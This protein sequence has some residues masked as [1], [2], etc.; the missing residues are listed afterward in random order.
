MSEA[1]PLALDAG[2]RRRGPTLAGGSPRRALRLS[3]AGWRTLAQLQGG[4]AR[5]EAALALGRRL[6][7]AGIAHPRPRPRARL[8]DVTVVI[9]VRDRPGELDRCLSAL[10]PGLD[11]I[12]ADDGSVDATAVAG[13]VARHGARLVRGERSDGPAAARNA[14]LAHAGSELIA[15]LDSDCA[16]EPGWLH[17]L[18]GHF[19][20]PLVGAAAPRIRPLT[21]PRQ[22]AGARFLAGRSP[23]DM[24]RHESGVEPGGIVGY[25]PTAALVVRRLA[26]GAGFDEGLRYG[27]DVDLVWRMRDGGWRVRYDPSVTVGHREP[28]SV[29]RAWARRFRYGTSAG[30]LA[31][32]HP[33]RMA[34]ALIS[35]WPSLA[36]ALVIGRRRRAAAVIAAGHSVV[37]GRRLAAL[38]LPRW[39]G[40]RW[41]GEATY[42]AA[43]SMTRYVAMLGLPAAVLAARRARSPWALGWLALPALE[44]WR[45]RRPALDPVRWTALA[46][47][48]DAAYGAGV[49]WGALCSRTARP[50]RPAVVRG[51]GSRCAA[52]RRGC[53]DRRSSGGPASAIAPVVGVAVPGDAAEQ[54]GQAADR[55]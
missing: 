33:G 45:R 17:A 8:A 29:T 9:P 2:V 13:I 32:R 22:G 19:D 39:W 20:D 28:E 46:L 31:R 42:H 10:G 49:W 36:A 1:P 5:S 27:E 53:G 23:L 55:R 35:P 15:F 48:D 43:V 24:G 26:L 54:P 14:A 52:E 11:V 51:A 25:V 18:A 38:G 41:H 30:P 4:T 3:E 16:P 47:A 21:G 50:L 40:P 6:L 44:D 7:D 34:P 12:V 37:L